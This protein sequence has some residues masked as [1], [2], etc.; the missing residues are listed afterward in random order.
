[1]TLK[2][3][4]KRMKRARRMTTEELSEKSGVPRG[5]INKL[6][7]G[8]TQNPTASTLKALCAALECSVGA[9]VGEPAAAGDPG[10]SL[11]PVRPVKTR[12]PL[13]GEIAAG[14][15]LFCEEACETIGG[16]NFPEG[17]YLLRVKGDS[18][19]GARIRSGDLVFLRP[20]EDVPDGKIAAVEIDGFATLKRVYHHAGGLTLVSENPKYPPMV[21]TAAEHER[22][23]ILGLAVGL[24]S[25]Q[26]E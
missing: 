3:N 11:E 18:M 22:V 13:L 6:L 4:L 15:P 25:T 7:I 21:F 26:L 2:E 20:Q 12:A 19:T 14:K 24:Q 23:R 5:T 10:C 9:L 1:M 17:V 16:L 8:D